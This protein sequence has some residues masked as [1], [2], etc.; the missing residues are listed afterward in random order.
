[1]LLGLFNPAGGHPIDWANVVSRAKS[2][3]FGL[4]YVILLG[5]ALYHGLYGF[6]NIVFELNLPAFVRRTVN[7]SLLIAG[8]ALFSL[9][10]WAAYA[11]FR[12][13]QSS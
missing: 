4:T 10:T 6:R 3:F 13:A 11:S 8:L 12:L 7:V 1:L 2:G 9:G 5:A